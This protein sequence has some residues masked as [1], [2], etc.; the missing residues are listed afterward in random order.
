MLSAHKKRLW[1][2]DFSLLDATFLRKFL[3]VSR[4]TNFSDACPPK[5]LCV[6]AARAYF[7]NRPSSS[8][9]LYESSCKFLTITCR[10]IRIELRS[11]EFSS[12]LKLLSL[13]LRFISTLTC[14]IAAN[15][16]SNRLTHLFF[17]SV[18]NKGFSVP[19]PLLKGLQ[20]VYVDTIVTFIL[21]HHFST[22][23]GPEHLAMNSLFPSSYHLL[24]WGC[25]FSSV[26][27]CNQCHFRSLTSFLILDC[28]RSFQSTAYVH[29][30]TRVLK[31][32]ILKLLLRVC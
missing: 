4:G 8:W 31:F 13:Y 10:K 24:P 28:W 7:V 2:S 23:T 15:F 12:F 19:L 3:S 6:P 18:M 17:Y 29:D 27:V 26:L 25:P 5:T 16:P 22:V 1:G 32:R 9:N 14:T 20:C 11:V 30:Q 21:S